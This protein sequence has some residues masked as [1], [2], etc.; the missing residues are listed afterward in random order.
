MT[1]EEKHEAALADPDNPPM[2]PG[3][4][5]RMRRISLAKFTRQKLGMSQDTFSDT[6]AI[7]LDTLRA[8]ERHQAEPTPAETSFLKAIAAAPDVVRE[9]LA[10]EHA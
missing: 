5:A 2:T 10:R 1:E 3:Q 6:Y 8:W 4:L 9:A 7:P